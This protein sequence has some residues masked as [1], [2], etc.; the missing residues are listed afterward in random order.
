MSSLALPQSASCGPCIVFLHMHKTGGSTILGA[1]NVAKISTSCGGLY[2]CNW[3][4]FDSTS[5]N[6]G[7]GLLHNS[8][9]VVGVDALNRAWEAKRQDLMYARL[10]FGGY[11]ASMLHP[12]SRPMQR[13]CVRIAMFRDPFA[14]LVSA[15]HYCMHGHAH[16]VP[17]WENVRRG[18]DQ[19]CG[20]MRNGSIEAWATHFGSWMFR[21]L[22]LQPRTLG[23]MSRQNDGRRQEPNLSGD[24]ATLTGWLR[25][26]ALIRSNDYDSK[27][28]M[29]ARK[30]LRRIL[31]SIAEG[32][33]FDVPGIFEQWEA[34]MS[35]LDAIVPLA[36]GRTWGE[37]VKAHTETHGSHVWR[38]QKAATLML[39]R[40]SASVQRL[41][42]ADIHVYAAARS[43][44]QYLCRLRQIHTKTSAYDAPQQTRPWR[45]AEWQA[46]R[47]R[48]RTQPTRGAL[49]GRHGPG[50]SA[51]LDGQQE[52]Q[53]RPARKAQSLPRFYLHTEASFKYVENMVRR[54]VQRGSV[55]DRI[56]IVNAEHLLDFFLLEAM[57]NG[58][59]QR[60]FDPNLA[61]LHFT[62]ALISSSTSLR[63]HLQ[64]ND[65]MV[66]A[67]TTP[68]VAHV[69]RMRALAE[70]LHRNEHFKTRKPFFVQVSDWWSDPR[71]LW[72]VLP[73]G[74]VVLG[75]T[76]P[77]YKRAEPYFHAKRYQS[78][79]VLPYRAHEL[80]SAPKDT[81]TMLRNISL[82][83]HGNCQRRDPGVRSAML[84]V[85]DAIPKDYVVSLRNVELTKLAFQKQTA[86]AVAA[87]ARDMRRAQLCLCPTGDSLSSRRVFDALAAGCVPVL[88]VTPG[89][90]GFRYVEGPPTS[91]GNYESA[92]AR[93]ASRYLPFPNVIDWRDIAVLWV[94]SPRLD[95]GVAFLTQLMSPQWKQRRRRM[96][97]AGR[98]AFD[99]HLNVQFN[100]SGVVSSIL[101]NFM[102][103][104]EGAKRE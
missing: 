32:S 36:H 26:K 104:Q 25:V 88:M 103:G 43:R 56:P 81:L 19:L 93:Y 62:D 102:A 91:P 98:A 16:G 52:Q 9:A 101:A 44:F 74:N 99:A 3:R 82:L 12:T 87:S 46:A 45:A 27:R 68:T 35:L 49:H 70:S 65:R 92:L 40:G 90:T 86:L 20:G 63:A 67:S 50:R 22:A 34:T 89:G 24:E 75:T 41:L 57:Q 2:Y 1:L 7:I 39:A 53:Q 83:F 42:E 4:A 72:E 29:P 21:L 85:L 51:L 79:E 64:S 15:M 73:E 96:R 77:G 11:A 76:D 61:D 59:P 33:L 94:M 97:E 5:C 54:S 48:A 84:K 28:T 95:E 47:Q 69:K 71:E 18:G 100:A 17:A 8:T 55:D 31:K 37:E 60:T 38:A 13:A 78:Y 58:H 6:E 30:V 10:Y 66:A 23:L 80:L 14:R